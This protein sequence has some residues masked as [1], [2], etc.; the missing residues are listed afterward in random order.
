MRNDAAGTFPSP[1]SA[2]VG[3]KSAIRA[4]SWIYIEIAAIAAFGLHI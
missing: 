4:V 1:N 3:A 2:G